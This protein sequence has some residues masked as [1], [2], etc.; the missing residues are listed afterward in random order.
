MAAPQQ[1]SRRK[2]AIV[3]TIVGIAS[4]GLFLGLLE[5]QVLAAPA[6]ERDSVAAE[7]A[8]VTKENQANEAILRDYQQ[9]LAE[10]EQ[11][12][13]RF[14]QILETIPPESE[15]PNVLTDIKNL[16]GAANVNLASF[17]PGAPK[18]IQQP[19]TKSDGKPAGAA[20]AAAPEPPSDLPTLHE[21]P[22][23]ISVRTSY[24]NLTSLFT[25]VQG[26]T[27]LIHLRRFV[28]RVNPDNTSH[29]ILAEISLSVYFKKPP[30]AARAVDHEA[31]PKP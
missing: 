27:R 24:A 29:P 14:H 1:A 2:R 6:A 22:I 11:R 25:R 28:S 19:A 20:G 8:R 21:Q 10:H 30:E 3:A 17:N 15:L 16:T 4:L 26:E 13:A 12:A 5:W 7:L 23:E 9:F 31:R 18:P